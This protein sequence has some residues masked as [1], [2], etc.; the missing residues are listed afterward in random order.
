MHHMKIVTALAGTTALFAIPLLAASGAHAQAPRTA[1]R[2]AQQQA[3][4]AQQQQQAPPAQQQAVPQFVTSPWAK[5]CETQPQKVCI[6]RSLVLTEA[7]APVA[8]A[9]L[10]EPEGAAAMLRFT[11]PLGMLLEYGTRLLV[12]QTEQPLATGRFVVCLQGCITFYQASTDLLDKLKKGKTLYIQA[13]NANNA[14]MSF[15]IPLANF[16]KA[17]DGA[18][19]DAKAYVEQQKKLQEELQKKAGVA[20]QPKQ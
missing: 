5:V 4:P 12:D 7:G 9:E 10:A 17:H 20:A 3:Q 11:L 1:P 18:P 2:Q 15:P 8:L 13:V 14:P 16:A 19:I 6:T